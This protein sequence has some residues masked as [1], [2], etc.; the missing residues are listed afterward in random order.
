MSSNPPSV[1]HS[2]NGGFYNL[3]SGIG[4]FFFTSKLDQMVN[5]LM[6]VPGIS[7]M[8]IPNLSSIDTLDISSMEIELNGST[9]VGSDG[10]KPLK[11]HCCPEWQRRS[12]INDIF[13]R[14]GAYCS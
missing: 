11:K 5:R 10:A 4:L 1:R 13:C 9:N 2:G 12:P 14:Y 6:S 3:D 8:N 7:S